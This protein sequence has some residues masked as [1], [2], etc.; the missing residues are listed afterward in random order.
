[1]GAHCLDLLSLWMLFL[2]FRQEISIGALVAGFAIGVLFWIV[3]ITPQGIGV[4]EG[5][6]ALVFVSLGVPAP[7]A[8]VIAVAFRALTFWLPLGIG[9]LSLRRL[10]QGQ[11]QLAG[12]SDDWKVH[13]LALLVAVMGVINVLSA[14]TPS[15]PTRLEPLRRLFPLVV[16][17]GSHLAAALAGFALLLIAD[18]LWRRKRL[19]WALAIATLLVSAVAHMIKGLDYEEA[20]LAL[21][22][23]L[24]L[25]ACRPLFHARSDLP[26]VRRGLVTLLAAFGFTLVYGTAGFYLLDH[27][28]RIAYALGPAVRQ[29]AIL[30]T[31]FYDPGFEPTTVFSRYFA[32]SIYLVG[33]VTTGYA[34]LMLL[35]P[36]LLRQPATPEA[37]RRAVGVVEAYGRSS[38]A[39]MTLFDDKSYF[40]SP[41]GSVVAFVAKGRAALALG[42]PIGPPEDVEASV[43][44]FQRL[45]SGND[46]HPVFY[47][48][49]PDHLDVYRRAG[50]VSLCVGQEAIVDLPGFSLEGHEHKDFR[51]AVHRLARS[52]F[53]AEVQAPPIATRLLNELRQVSDEWLTLVHGTEKRFS[54]GWF[55]DDY[56]RHS[57]LITV[58][59]SENTVAAFAN[60]VPEY[61]LNEA[62]LDL[63]RHR[64]GAPPGTMDFLFVSLIDWA[65]S[66]GYDSFNLG[67]SSLAGVGDEPQ[68]PT[69]EKALHFVYEHVNSFYNFKGLHGFKAK[70]NPRWSPRYL[71]YPGATSLPII[72]AGIAR[73]DSGGGLLEGL[74]RR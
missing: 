45:C 43:Q 65:R 17:H 35:R 12:R 49:L 38:L 2:A 6:M 34:L 1:M 72:L 36:V 7:Q 21:V 50:F 53:R 18:G 22:L 71:I 60:I 39:R 9:A 31:Q 30:F 55:D 44:G 67:L 46:W 25:L 54:L 32:D 63:M 19:A 26:S 52:G 37:R 8:T 13:G 15:L 47:Q 70:F 28:F 16:R 33:L 61:R 27:H 29:T 51:N 11:P 23:V 69:L 14:V 64:R 20:V 10:T 42:D 68:D 41:G 3:S 24:P 58:T 59:S 57:S 73:A 5:A 74:L 66:K 4:V 56:I 40:F 62:S 48:V